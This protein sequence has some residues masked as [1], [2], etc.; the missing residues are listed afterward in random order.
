[1]GIAPELHAL[2]STHAIRE[3]CAPCS[4]PRSARCRRAHA[5]CEQ[6][7][8][9]RQALSGSGGD[10]AAADL[11]FELAARLLGL[12]RVLEEKLPLDVQSRH[13]ALRQPQV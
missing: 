12:R 1:M 10:C 7:Q 9:A 6:Q 13:R 5:A 11:S 2:N 3:T 8:R 4:T